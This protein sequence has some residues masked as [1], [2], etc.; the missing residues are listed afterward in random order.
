MTRNEF[1]EK[2]ADT[3]RDMIH[4][5]MEI[6]LARVPKNNGV[7]LDALSIMMPGSNIA[8]THYLDAY[9]RDFCGG[10][11]IKDLAERILKENRWYGS[12]DFAE[13][14]LFGEFDKISK[15]LRY[16][17]INYDMNREL[18]QSVPHV[19]YLDLAKIY[20]FVI[21]NG[22]GN[23]ASSYVRLEDL[24]SWELTERELD[25]QAEE[26]MPEFEPPRFESIC[27][28]LEKMSGG[29]H[30]YEEEG[31]FS[32]EMF[33][34]MYVLSNRSRYYGASCMLYPGLLDDLS[35]KFDTGYYILPSSIH[36]LIILPDMGVYSRRELEEMVTEINQSHV[37]REEVLS[38]HVYYYSRFSGTVS[39]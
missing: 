38:N 28:I 21:E 22:L 3:L 26:N 39:M 15:N 18:L 7:K 19:R 35:G 11:P 34:P 36:E 1:N 31:M 12:P 13:G 4:D 30:M 23:Y 27:D 14:G 17:L 10:A 16:R 20:Y 24:K 5:G 32:P 37:E 2:L 33:A 6:S 29:F 25:E 8:P 9:Y